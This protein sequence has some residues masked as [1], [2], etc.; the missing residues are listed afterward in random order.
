MSEKHSGLAVEEREIFLED[1]DQ[2]RDL[3]A[4]SSEERL[5]LAEAQSSEKLKLDP[6]RRVRSVSS[7]VLRLD[8]GATAGERSAN[9]CP[10]GGKIV[11]EV[12][13]CGIC[14]NLGNEV[15]QF[16]LFLSSLYNLCAVVAKRVWSR[17][18]SYEDRQHHAFLAILTNIKTILG[19]RNP[20]GMAHSIAKRSLINLTERAV[21]KNEIPVSQL[22][23]K[24]P[25]WAELSNWKRLEILAGAGDEKEPFAEPG[26][27]C[28]FT[29]FPGVRSLW[30]PQYLRQL[31]IGLE[32]AFS[33]LPTRPVSQSHA[34]KLWFGMYPEC[35][36]LSYPEIARVLDLSERQARYQVQQG[37]SNLRR[38][39]EEDAK[40]LVQ[41]E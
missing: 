35:G 36:E 10:H 28:E 15:G 3:D 41:R 23:S 22:G 5:D 12:A 4:V 30:K 18:V 1:M 40:Q 38:L 25:N 9:L 39:L 8:D 11:N 19:A 2:H 37:L 27:S 13:Y 33:H 20:Q 14:A 21:N 6:E 29:Y 7:Q 26:R 34:I 17:S 32:K 16:D 31:E 24:E